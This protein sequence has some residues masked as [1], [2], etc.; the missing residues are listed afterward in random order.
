MTPL[1]LVRSKREHL[2]RLAN[3]KGATGEVVVLHDMKHWFSRP[4]GAA[5]RFLLSALREEG[6]I[7]KGTSFDAIYIPDVLSFDFSDSAAVLSALPSMTFIE[8]KTANQ[9]RV[10]QGFGG[11]FFALTESEISAA[12]MLGSRHRVALFNNL[13]GELQLTS[14]SEL[15]ERAKSTNWQLSLQL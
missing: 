4:V 13:T 6:K 7:I 8:I 5:L 1:E 2:A 9:A 15:L 3:T 10:K 11:F 14:V 12:D